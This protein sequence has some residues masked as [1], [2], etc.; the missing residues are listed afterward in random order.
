MQRISSRQT[1]W[2]KKGF[3]TL[4]FGFLGLF[5]L[6][7]LTGVIQQQVPAPT[8]LIPVG[9]AVFGYVFMRWWVL[10]IVDEVW[11]QDEEMFGTAPRRIA[12]PLA[13]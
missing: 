10:P 1:W 7:W 2:Y 11:M 6:A 9:M 13:T 3:P 5:S 8:I 12:F 4:W